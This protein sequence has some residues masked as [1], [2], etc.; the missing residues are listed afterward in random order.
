MQ[1]LFALDIAGHTTTHVVRIFQ[2]EQAMQQH[3]FIADIYSHA[4]A[5]IQT[6]QP[7]VLHN[8]SHAIMAQPLNL[9]LMKL[10]RACTKD[11]MLTALY[12]FMRPGHCGSPV[13]H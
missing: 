4:I 5:H 3:I 10:G 1:P 13:V 7:P 8:A 2:A 6:A 11:R 9:L 12:D